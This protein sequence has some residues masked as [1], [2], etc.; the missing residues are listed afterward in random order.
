ME[1]WMLIVTVLL[2]TFGSVLPVI[3]AVISGISLGLA[4]AKKINHMMAIR[5]VVA[6]IALLTG[7]LG[8]SLS[9]MM[10]VPGSYAYWA[11]LTGAGL[12]V[13]VIAC[14]INLTQ[15]FA[16]IHA[17][18]AVADEGVRPITSAPSAYAQTTGY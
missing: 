17:E 3:A 15:V 1:I 16:Q 12:C 14:T 11:F 8:L 2:V 9:L 6:C 13:G 10:L 4:K 18:E 7:G 5:N